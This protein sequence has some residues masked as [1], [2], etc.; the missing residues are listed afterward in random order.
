MFKKY[1]N[2]EPKKKWFITWIIIDIFFFVCLFLAYGPFTFFKDF[3]I[4]T[5]MTTYTH[6]YL[7]NVFYND[8]TI[9]KVV[10]NNYIVESGQDTDTS[11]ITFVTNNSGVYDSEYEKAILQHDASDTYKVI[12][13]SGSGYVGWIVAVYDPS[14]VSLATASNMGTIGETISTIA[15]NNEAKVAINASGFDDPNWM[16]NGG[17]PTGVVIKDSKIIYS[18]NVTGYSGGLIGFNK[19]N[20][21]VL[22]KD[23]AYQ[24]IQDG[25]RDAVTFGPFLI[26]NGEASFIKGNGG[27]GIAPRTAIAQR[28]DGIVLFLIIDGRQPGYSIGADMVEVTRVLQNYGAYNAAN[29][30]GGAS[31]GL[32]IEGKLYNKPCAASTSGERYIPDAWI[33]K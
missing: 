20:V 29:L 12:N 25:M 33:V 17:N 27:W 14:R 16:G 3:W 23:N 19:N 13:I 7:A 15:Q 1:E 18:G 5:A 9:Q 2:K 21:L 26:V 10:S 32:A 6:Q 11:A 30:D 8:T 31:T 24:A 22:T 4:T 28:K